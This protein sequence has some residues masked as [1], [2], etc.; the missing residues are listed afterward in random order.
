[1]RIESLSLF[2]LVVEKGCISKAARQAY[3]S[4]QGA[5]SI[6]KSLEHDFGVTLFERRGNDLHLTETGKRIAQEAEQVV[7]AYRRLQTIAALGKANGSSYGKPL[8]VVATPFT[9][10]TFAPIFDAYSEALGVSNP[11][12]FTEKSLFEIVSE[13]PDLDDNVLYI[14]NIPS[15]MAHMVEEIT[16]SFKPLVTS[17]L[18]LYCRADLPYA[19]SK[20]IAKADLANAQIACYKEELL[21]RLIKNLIKDIP[22]AGIRVQTTNLALLNEAILEQGLVS[23]TDSFSVFLGGS[24]PIGEATVVPIIDSTKLT[25]GILG[26]YSGEQAS[27]LVSFMESYFAIICADYMERFPLESVA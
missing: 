1:M 4:Q 9:L 27:Y 17:D 26:S 7:S 25:T 8:R 16:P 13:Y 24:L 21:M 3:I 14:I 10:H 2:L 19:K 18:M 15:F 11:L 5:S 20:V 12:E 23:F 6:I 22:G